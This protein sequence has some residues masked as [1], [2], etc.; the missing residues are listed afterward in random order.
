MNRREFLCK[1]GTVV[2]VL[3]A[4]FS[5]GCPPEEEPQ[6]D[7]W[8]FLSSVDDGHS[9]SFTLLVDEVENPPQGGLQ[10]ETTLDGGH[11]HTVQLSE[12]ELTEI[13]EGNVVEKETS[14]D[15]GHSH[16]FEFQR[17]S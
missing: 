6:P 13:D 9:H 17:Q 11:V 3:P 5:F 15:A 2:L 8:E 12:A 1:A 14:V 16:T 10:D 4:S 7:G